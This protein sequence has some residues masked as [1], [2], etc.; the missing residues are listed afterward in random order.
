[1]PYG[2]PCGGA[3]WALGRHE[4]D[5]LHRLAGGL[6]ITRDGGDRLD[7]ALLHCDHNLAAR[8][9]SNA[10]KRGS[11][12]ATLQSA[13]A[14]ACVPQAGVGDRAEIMQS[15]QYRVS[16]EASGLGGACLIAASDDAALLA[17]LTARFFAIA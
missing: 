4:V 6:K 2:V 1:M 11:P 14:R 13:H 16:T 17:R 5:R 7:P 3:L 8:L 15:F 10:F 9:F 12:A